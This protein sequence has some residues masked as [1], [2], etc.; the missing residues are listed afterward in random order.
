[1][2]VESRNIP[3]QT[4]HQLNSYLKN[5]ILSLSPMQLLVKVYD[6]AIIGCKSKDMNKASKALVELISGLRFEYEEISVGLFRLYQYC[7][8]EIKKE[9]YDIPLKVLTELRNTWVEIDKQS[10]SAKPDGEKVG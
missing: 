7:L 5:Q 6:V 4:N 3:V 9:N 2:A 8:D 1:M 10:L